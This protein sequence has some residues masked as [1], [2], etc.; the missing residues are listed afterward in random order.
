[1]AS[2]AQATE[3]APSRAAEGTAAPEAPCS[4]QPEHSAAKGSACD[5]TDSSAATGQDDGSVVLARLREAARAYDQQC[6]DAVVELL[7]RELSQRAIPAVVRDPDQLLQQADK[8]CEDGKFY[9]AYPAFCEAALHCCCYMGHN[10][11]LAVE[12]TWNV[13]RIQ[14]I[15]CGGS[16][17]P[18]LYLYLLPLVTKL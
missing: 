8:L 5:G 9:E 10:H 4:T 16:A 13:S 15:T 1:M 14:E 2:G 3:S 6:A 18:A 17:E 7:R 11:E 12:G